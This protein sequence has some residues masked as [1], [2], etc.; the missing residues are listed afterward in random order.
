M[1]LGDP[2]SQSLFRK[3]DTSHK[4]CEKRRDEMK[5]DTQAKFKKMQ[6]KWTASEKLV[7]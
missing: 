6:N 1:T 7:S 3:L 2:S 5:K 4:D